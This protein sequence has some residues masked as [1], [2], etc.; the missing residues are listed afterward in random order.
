[1]QDNINELLGVYNFAKK[2]GVGFGINMLT[3]S[4][5][6]FGH[7]KEVLAP[8][9]KDSIIYTLSE[10]VKRRYNSFS[11]RSI[12]SG[13]FEEK[14]LEFILT[15][16]RIPLCSAGTETVFITPT[17]NVYPCM[18][19]PYRFGNLR[20]QGWEELWCSP[21]AEEIRKKVKHCNKCWQRCYLY[22]Y[23]RYLFRVGWSFLKFK[24]K[25]VF[26]R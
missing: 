6:Y 18:I 17:G 1:M 10:L 4:P 13:W 2:L 16:K 26:F 23:P 7:N 21:K 5:I 14:L 8:Q 11:P 20:E 9:N 3:S 19:L 24:L 25:N 12:F 22:P 15:G